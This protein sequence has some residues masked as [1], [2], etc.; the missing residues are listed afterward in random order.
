MSVFLRRDSSICFAQRK[1]ILNALFL[2]TTSKPSK[3]LAAASSSQDTTSSSSANSGGSSSSPARTPPKKK[4]TKKPK[5]FRPLKPLEPGALESSKLRQHLK[6]IEDT[7]DELVLEDLE[8]HKPAKVADSRP[9][10]YDKQYAELRRNIIRSFSVPQIQKFISMYGITLPP[11][12]KKSKDL[13]T[14]LILE[15]WGWKPLRV[16]REERALWR[17][18]SVKEYPMNSGSAFVFMGQ[19]GA[20]L[21]NLAKRYNVHLSF[22]SDPLSLRVQGLKGA[23]QQLDG[24]LKV[25]YEDIAQDTVELPI[26]LT[27]SVEMAH[28]LS[29]LSGAYAEPLESGKILVTYRKRKPESVHLL[30][31]LAVQA[32][33]QA[34]AK[35]RDTLQVLSLT[36]NASQDAPLANY[37]FYPFFPSQA[38]STK[39][40]SSSPF[41]LRRIG[42]WLRAGARVS[43]NSKDPNEPSLSHS[44]NLNVQRLISDKLGEVP[45]G[46]TR[47]VTASIGHVLFLSE[48]GKS[49][50]VPPIA[51][52]VGLDA[53]LKLA[54][55]KEERVVFNAGVPKSVMMTWP[56]TERMLQRLVYKA[57]DAAG[58]Q[59]ESGPSR[60]L[61]VELS[62]HVPS[63]INP[64]GSDTHNIVCKRSIE[65]T[66]DILLSARTT[67]LHLAAE[68]TEWIPFPEMPLELRTYAALSLSRPIAVIPLVLELDGQTYVLSS[69][70][71]LRRSYH[72][73][74]VPRTIAGIEDSSRQL[75]CLVEATVN[76]ENGLDV[77]ECKLRCKDPNSDD[78]W[79]LFLQQCDIL[80]TIDAN[81]VREHPFE[82]FRSWQD[83]MRPTE[84]EKPE[85]DMNDTE[86]TKMFNMPVRNADNID[87][88]LARAVAEDA[89]PSSPLS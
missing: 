15:R 19:D 13:C 53:A 17:D 81:P 40:Q 42:E 69:S 84:A 12:R 39:V 46:S 51:G 44:S 89:K 55:E 6:H 37:S 60:M 3:G 25:F 67:D 73:V 85:A 23:I 83:E 63:S 29:R 78:G 82:A 1:G 62:E 28:E 65:T 27:I 64:E 30:K 74:T 35:T 2:S 77:A 72:R 45:E 33:S 54:Q 87:R 79:K 86:I 76:P 48:V 34:E 71:Q 58:K 66:M 61:T 14:E 26:G 8:R 32:A 43:I 18:T 16:V 52:I 49:T 7:K 38:T 36:S 20:D 10:T 11:Y 50:L 57:Y 22:N 70:S 80:T 41:R 31:R 75:E 9:T 88:I 24:Y 68:D 47:V 21:L 59:Q 4:Y 56:D 5:V